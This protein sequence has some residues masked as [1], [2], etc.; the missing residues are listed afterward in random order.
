M[1][2]IYLSVLLCIGSK[3]AAQDLIYLTDGTKLPGK[4]TE[5]TAEKVKF[6]NMA[7]PSGPTY[8]RT[9]DKVSFVFNAAGDYLV[10]SKEKPFSD[11]DRDA[12]LAGAAK[13][14]FLDALV[15]NKGTV[16]ST[17]IASETDADVVCNNKG[18][19]SKVAKS[20]LAFLIRRDGSH[21]VF[22]SPEQAAPIL[23]ASQG[24]ISSA[25][26]PAAAPQAVPTPEP[27]TRLNGTPAV[28]GGS[29]SG[30]AGAV[31]SP[32]DMKLFNR[33]ALEKT[34][35]FTGY[36]KMIVAVN[37]NKETAK[38]GISLACALFL[39]DDSRVEVSNVNSDVRNKY[40]IREY[41]NRLML[42][43]GQFDKVQIEYA[44]V[45]YAS[46]FKKGADGN[47]YGVVTFVQTF[48]GFVDDKV[49]YGDVTK[50]NV[51]VVLKPYEKAVNGE[52]VAAW[53]VFLDDVG[54]V[55]TKKI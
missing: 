41:L 3:L 10:F 37:T 1:K 40:K 13:S 32:M 11:K 35:E 31:V 48:R 49:V 7:N 29:E 15:D 52:S 34:E 55:E 5:I 8:S 4:V 43:S 17:I 30:T 6:K 19:E 16:T 33:K 28:A 18:E 24:K 20:S 23:L 25:L 44:N 22:G 21:Q 26:P 47:Y 38:K 9:P 12:F 14:R 51:T 39:N 53:D 36:M 2:Y 42:R 50:R 45:N 54:V 27:L 46:K